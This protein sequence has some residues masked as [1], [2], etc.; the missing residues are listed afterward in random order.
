[1]SVCSVFSLQSPFAAA[2]ACQKP[3]TTNSTLDRSNNLS[4]GSAGNSKCINNV[5]RVAPRPKN[6]SQSGNNSH[7]VRQNHFTNSGTGSY[8]PNLFATD[9]FQQQQQQQQTTRGNN[10]NGRNG[11]TNPGMNTMGSNAINFSAYQQPNYPQYAH[12]APR[13]RSSSSG[14]EGG[15]AT[16]VGGNDAGTSPRNANIA[17]A[18]K[19]INDQSGDKINSGASFT[20]QCSGGKSLLP[21][22]FLISRAGQSK[23]KLPVSASTTGRQKQQHQQPHQQQPQLEGDEGNK[24]FNSLKSSLAG[25]RKTPQLY[26]SMRIGEGQAAQQQQGPQTGKSCKRHQ[27]FNQTKSDNGGAFEE[28]QSQSQGD[29]YYEGGEQ[30]H[31][32]YYEE[33]PLYENLTDSIQIHELSAG[34][35]QLQGEQQQATLVI[36]EQ[37][38][39]KHHQKPLKQIHQ[40]RQHKPHHHHHHQQQQLHNGEKMKKAHHKSCDMIERNSIYRSDS[41]IS[42]S[43]YECITPVPAPRAANG[44]LVAAGYEASGG[45]GGGGTASRKSKKKMPVYMNLAC[46]LGTARETGGRGGAGTDCVDGGKQRPSAAVNTTANTNTNPAE[47]CVPNFNL[48]IND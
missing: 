43:S 4:A 23:G 31:T 45:G 29:Y 30:Q 27:S 11:G 40:H 42:N 2:H 25:L 38:Q 5:V 20:D 15:G 37:K 1:M 47:V 39:P 28:E 16:A 8:R 41:G 3:L 13:N 26:Y 36:N 18:H 6:P 48:I 10:D 14:R 44:E 34:S 7:N 33:Q 35:V 22:P 19:V 12:T 46:H 21:N 9:Y 24:K 32:L 17:G